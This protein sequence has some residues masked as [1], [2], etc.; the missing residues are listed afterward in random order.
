MRSE[1]PVR[2]WFSADGSW[3]SWPILRPC[4]AGHSLSRQRDGTLLPPDTSRFPQFPTTVAPH[5]TSPRTAATSLRDGR[6]CWHF[7][8]AAGHFIEEAH[9]HPTRRSSAGPR[10]P[11]T[12][13]GGEPEFGE[14]FCGLSTLT[15]YGPFWT[16][17]GTRRFCSTRQTGLIGRVAP[18]YTQ[19]VDTIGWVKKPRDVVRMMQNGEALV[20]MRSGFRVE[21]WDLLK[22]RRLEDWRGSRS[23]FP[24]FPVI[25]SLGMRI[26]SLYQTSRS[27]S[28]AL[29]TFPLTL[30]TRL[31]RACQLVAS[32]E[33]RERWRYTY[34]EVPLPRRCQQ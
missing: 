5:S 28:V 30:E 31:T 27:L 22:K 2:T 16:P 23:A 26:A 13:R 12:R 11:Q 15:R 3:L 6:V 32:V 25:D 4:V 1:T 20:I 29:D 9:R 17:P 14:A 33:A 24:G 34:K 19:P 7:G 18:P 21:T 10:R 8:C